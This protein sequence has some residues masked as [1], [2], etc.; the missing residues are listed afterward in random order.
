VDFKR[1]THRLD[2][3][4]YRGEKWYFVTMCCERRAPIFLDADNAAWIIEALHTESI[5]HQ[6]LVDA[7]CVMPD[8]LH[9]LAFGK[10]ASCDLLIFAKTFKQ[11][12]A[13]SYMQKTHTRLWLKNYYDHILQSNEESSRV[14]AYI[15]LNPVRK[16]LC[17]NFEDYPFSGSFVRPWKAS[18]ELPSWTPPWKKPQMPA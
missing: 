6:F 13:Y 18:P 12:S 11:K 15:W 14:A 10:A 9:F 8:H 17:K 4:E 3:L 2:P 1:K 16:G 5:L 7:Y